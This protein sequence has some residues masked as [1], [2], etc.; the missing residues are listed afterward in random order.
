LHTAENNEGKVKIL[1]EVT[2]LAV[3]PV[4]WGH[5]LRKRRYTKYMENHVKPSYC[6]V[7]DYSVQ[8]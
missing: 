1:N 7:Y 3:R 2:W 6:R 8:I 4:K 5:L